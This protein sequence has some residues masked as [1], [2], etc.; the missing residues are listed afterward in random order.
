MYKDYKIDMNRREGVPFYNE[1]GF[2]K[3]HEAEKRRKEDKKHKKKRKDG[4]R[5]KN[6][7]KMFKDSGKIPVLKE[8]YK[9]TH[10]N[11]VLFVE[12]IEILVLQNVS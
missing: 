9:G 5:R 4:Q 2:T 1:K 3:G 6:A 12:D 8:N 7:E 10:K 11:F